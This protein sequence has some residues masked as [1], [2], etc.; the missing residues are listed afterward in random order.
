MTIRDI[1]APGLRQLRKLWLPFVAIQ[2]AGVCIVLAYFFVPPVT[3]GLDAVSRVKARVGWPFAAAAMAFAS[4]ILPELF[5][6]I[7]GVDR[8]WD[9]KRVGFTLHNL[10][11]F[12]VLGVAADAFYQLMAHWFGTSKSF[13][14]VLLKTALDQFVFSAFG[15]VVVLAF[16]FTWRKHNYRLAPTLR[17]LSPRWYATDVMPVLVVNWAY[18]G[19]MCLLMYTLPTTITFIFGVIGAAASATLLTA[20]AD[21]K[22]PNDPEAS[23]ARVKT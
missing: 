10:I 23:I 16:S 4:A 3:H 12:A 15:S 21:A 22:V 2:I 1:I 13:W 19:P 14:I 20:I 8:R 6:M 18:W 11:L 17:E 9:R 7:T 5:K